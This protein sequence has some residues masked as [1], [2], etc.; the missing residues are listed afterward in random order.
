MYGCLGLLNNLIRE[1][2]DSYIKLCTQGLLTYLT[3]EICQISHFLVR[4]CSINDH[5]D[6]SHTHLTPSIVF[7]IFL[8]SPFF[9]SHKTYFA[10]QWNILK[11]LF[12]LFCQNLNLALYCSSILY[13]LGKIV[14][15]AFFM[16]CLQF[17]VI[18]WIVS[19]WL[20]VGKALNEYFI[21]MFCNT[22][23]KTRL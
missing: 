5:S 12:L 23:E 17:Q 2:L 19:L 16:L 8:P 18:I 1:S 10:S 7:R 6:K 3:M 14:S 13:L 20:G 22:L 15:L 11:F 9:S 4:S 21:D